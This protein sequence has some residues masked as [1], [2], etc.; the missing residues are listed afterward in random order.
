MWDVFISHASEDKDFVRELASALE[1]RG[2]KVWFD[3]TTLKLGD[4]LGESIDK[5]LSQSRF[6]VVVFSL[7]FFRKSWPRYELEGL[8]NREMYHGKTILPIWHQIS[9]DEVAR[10]SPSLANKMAVSTDRG[11][12]QVVNQIMEVVAPDFN[13]LFSS[14]PPTIVQKP[15]DEHTQSA[16]KGTNYKPVDI[17]QLRDVLVTNFSLYELQDLCFDLGIDF[18]NVYGETR[19]AKA[20]ELIQYMDRRGELSKLVM[21]VKSLRPQVAW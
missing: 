9:A 16:I 13:S 7:A 15:I 14:Q 5:G 17:R 1:S 4:R 3:E 6:G 10:F 21:A 20:R 8:I 11:L 19:N 2:L 12:E 18:D